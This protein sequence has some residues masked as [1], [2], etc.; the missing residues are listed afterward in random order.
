MANLK[1]EKFDYFEYFLTCGNE[2]LESAE[3]LNNAF[4][5]FDPDK[6]QDNVKEI[7]TIERNADIQRHDMLIKLAHEFMTP[8]EFEDIVS[9]AKN[10]DD[11]IDAIDD[12]MQRAYMFNIKEMRPETLKFTELLVSCCKALVEIIEEFKNF[13]KSKTINQLIIKLNS[14]ENE[15]DMLFSKCMRELY[16]DNT[17][18][19]QVQIWSTIFEV[20]ENCFDVCEYA[21]H[22]IEVVIMKNT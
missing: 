9:L 6:L 3:Y 12:V 15:G 7:H 2:A 17:D 20:L 19:R 4:A 8:I 16:N 21:A 13:R 1:R 5:N 14:I 18:M 22:I 11:V 10:L